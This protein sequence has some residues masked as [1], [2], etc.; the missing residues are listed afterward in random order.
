LY[1]DDS[2]L[3]GKA[4][5]FFTDFKAAFSERFEI[6]D[7][8]PASWLLGCRIDRDREKRILRLNQEQYVSE[9][10]EEFGMR[11][12]THVGTPMAAK[13]VSKPRNEKLLTSKLF[14]FP[15]LIG[16]LLYCSNWTRPDITAVVNHLS[17][18]MFNCTVQHY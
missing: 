8:G 16:K 14:L 7:L 5:K 3:I 6:K 12:S 4:G 1:V 17:R 2:I 11:S 13:V 18:Y 10:I 9:I 15:T